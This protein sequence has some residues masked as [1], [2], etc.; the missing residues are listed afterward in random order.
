VTQ[1]SGL[2]AIFRYGEAIAGSPQPVLITGETGTGKELMAQALHR[3]SGRPGELV[4]VN[5]AGLDDTTFGHTRG[6]FYAPAS[7]R[8]PHR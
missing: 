6:A 7:R 2:L 1:S 3:L 5:V 8:S 4:A